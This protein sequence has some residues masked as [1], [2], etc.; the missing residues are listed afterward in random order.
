MIA[1]R[2]SYDGSP[3]MV[4]KTEVEHGFMASQA[5]TQTQEA[6]AVVTCHTDSV[7]FAR[8]AH[9]TRKCSCNSNKHL[10]CLSLLCFVPMSKGYES[11]PS[12]LE[13]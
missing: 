6:S 7:P 10:I 1:L 12:S 5:Q 4:E 13:I 9:G 3:L 11:S 8:H 2:A